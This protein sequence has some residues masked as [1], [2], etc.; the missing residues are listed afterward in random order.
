MPELPEVETLARGLQR[1]IAGRRIVSVT[2]GKTDFIDNPSALEEFL[3]GLSI[4]RVERFGKFMLL[5]LGGE[6][7]GNGTAHSV[8]A[9]SLLVH[10]G[11]TG[12]MAPQPAAEPFSKHTHARFLLDDGCELRY[13]DP[14]RFGR[15][16]YLAGEKL[17]AELGR[18]GVDPLEVSELE[19]GALLKSHKSRIKALLLDQSALRGVGNIYA[20]ESLWRAKIHPKR[21]AATISQGVSRKLRKALQDILRE[22]IA[23]RGSSISD[24]LDAQGQPGEYQ[25]RHRAYGREAKPCYRCKT[26]IRRVIVAGRSSYFCPKCQPAPKSVKHKLK[27]RKPVTSRRKPASQ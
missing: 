19:F 4:E 7:S 20:D 11:M 27:R 24:F 9:A 16:A 13:T 21:I 2:L 22:A 18:F 3:P 6:A 5:R 15:M 14:R 25:R 26:P 12:H 17:L 1:T 10:L 8:S 23:L